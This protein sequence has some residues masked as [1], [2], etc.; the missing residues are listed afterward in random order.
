[1]S[2][3]TMIREEHV[4]AANADVAPADVLNAVLDNVRRDCRTDTQL[5]LEESTVPHG[6]E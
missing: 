5:Y 3:E 2:S 6:G 4:V 1:M